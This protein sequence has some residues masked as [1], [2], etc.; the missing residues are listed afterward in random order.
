MTF[1]DAS[2]IALRVFREVAARGTLTAAAAALGYTQS[3]ASR[4]IAALER[5]VGGRVLARHHDGVRLTP[6]GRIVLRRA[7]AALDEIDAGTRELASA[8]AGPAAGGTV[9]LGWFASA[10][11]TVVPRALELLRRAHPEV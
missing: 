11:A 6:A 2:L 8:G 9:R 3:A 4:Q 7:A 5:A 10:G 1:A